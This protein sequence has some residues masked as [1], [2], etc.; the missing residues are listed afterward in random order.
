MTDK[1]TSRPWKY[2]PWHIAEGAATVTAGS[3]P[4]SDIICTTASDAVAALIVAA[5]NSYS[6]DKDEKVRALV[7]A[8]ENIA[9]RTDWIGVLVDTEAASYLGQA[10]QAVVFE[11]QEALRALGETA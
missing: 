7:E 11:A 2:W 4:A 6:P 9:K 8:L 3:S 1:A 5:V 10:L